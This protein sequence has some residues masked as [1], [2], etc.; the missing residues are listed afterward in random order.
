MT[1]ETRVLDRSRAHESWFHRVY[2]WIE[3]GALALVALFAVGA[4]CAVLKGPE[5]RQ[6]AERIAAQE[7]SEENQAFCTKHA[8]A[9]DLTACS[10]DL[11]RVRANEDKRRNEGDVFL[12]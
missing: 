5:I 12:P 8:S 4:A 3:V 1:I 7:I 2:R 10:A 9:G 11:A 6:A